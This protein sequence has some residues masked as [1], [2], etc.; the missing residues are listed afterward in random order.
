[1]DIFYK[2]SHSS[3]FNPIIKSCLTTEQ[4]KII[5]SLKSNPSQLIEKFKN[6][7][8][9]STVK[10]LHLPTNKQISNFIYKEKMKMNFFLF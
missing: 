5:V 3:N 2:G 8:G 9:E 4:K 1:M 7:A 6:D 10:N